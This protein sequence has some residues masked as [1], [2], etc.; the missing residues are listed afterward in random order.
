MSLE[1]RY[2][3]VAQMLISSGEKLLI[4][5]CRRFRTRNPQVTFARGQGR[6][7]PDQGHVTVR[8]RDSLEGA[9]AGV[10]RGDPHR[11]RQLLPTNQN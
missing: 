4:Q 5:S 2:S 9:A 8:R 11:D 3:T 1:A 6:T 10:D 7:S